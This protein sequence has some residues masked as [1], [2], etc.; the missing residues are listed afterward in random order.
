M[1]AGPM[2]RRLPWGQVSQDKAAKREGDCVTCLLALGA[3]PV[4]TWGTLGAEA[5]CQTG[6][7]D[8][9]TWA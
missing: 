1:G 3:A 4:L 8:A 7:G 9:L 5:V 2:L 6:R